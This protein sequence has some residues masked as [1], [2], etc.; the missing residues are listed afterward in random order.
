MSSPRVEPHP[1][2]LWEFCLRVYA[3]PGVAPSCLELQERY[4]VDVPLLLFSSWLAVVGVRLQPAQAKLAQSWVQDWQSEVVMAL[5]QLRT[6]LKSGPHP[7]PCADTEA[8]RATIKRVELEAEKVE[9]QTLETQAAAWRA[10][11][12]RDVASG[13]NL[14]TMF[15]ALSGVALTSSLEIESLAVIA[16]ASAA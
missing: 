13:D 2:G 9:L 8:L 3:A 15:T 11:A 7:A 1:E 6:R 5:R 12:A 14:A 10:E 4:N 16:A